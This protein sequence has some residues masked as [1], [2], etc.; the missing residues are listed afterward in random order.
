MNAV[1]VACPTCQAEVPWTEASSW[2]PFCS[3]RCR[4]IDFGEWASGGYAIAGDVLSESASDIADLPND[5]AR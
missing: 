3:A 2:R 1:T 5:L 4:A